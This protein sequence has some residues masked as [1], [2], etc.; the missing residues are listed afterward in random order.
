MR[1]AMRESEDIVT[2]IAAERE[3]TLARLRELAQNPQA[4]KSLRKR[5]RRTL[6]RY[7]P[8]ATV[9]PTLRFLIGFL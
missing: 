3:R 5:A 8:T 2:L 9:T 1:E 7:T 6:E 4:S